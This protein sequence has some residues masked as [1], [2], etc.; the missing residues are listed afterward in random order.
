MSHHN[1]HTTIGQSVIL[2]HEGTCRFCDRMLAKGEKAVIARVLNDGRKRYAHPDCFAHGRG[3]PAR[4]A[5]P[6][7]NNNNGQ[8]PLKPVMPEHRHARFDLVLKLAELRVPIFLPG[9]AGCGKTHLA[10]QVAEALGLPFGMI[11]CSAGMSESAILGRRVPGPDGGFVYEESLFVHIYENGGVFLFDEIDAADPNVLLVINAAIANGH[12]AIPARTEK[13]LATR[14]PNF[15]IM[16][17]ANTYGRG[18]DRLYVGRNQ[19]DEA[20]LDRFR[21]GTV[22]LEYDTKLEERLCPDKELLQAIWEIRQIAEVSKL[23]RIVSTRFIVDAWK[24]RQAGWEVKT[25]LEQL[26]LTWTEDERKLV[27]RVLKR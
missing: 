15:I 14:H 13:P 25:I 5:Q 1:G 19:L 9:P 17:A 22:P 23:R 8:S 16:A 10:R 3:V 21:L 7:E 6:T 20:T 27:A 26:V 11:S 2:D 24:A 4:P 12:L 18:A